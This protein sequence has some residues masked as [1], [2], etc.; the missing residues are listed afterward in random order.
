MFQLLALMVAGF[1]IGLV[2]RFILAGMSRKKMLKMENDMLKNHSR[3]LSL[4]QKI[5]S[6]EAAGHD[7]VK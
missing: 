7:P 3:I 1:A 2:T 5:S 6:L 4:Q